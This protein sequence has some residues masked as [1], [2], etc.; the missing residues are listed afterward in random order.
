MCTASALIRQCVQYEI[1]TPDCAKSKFACPS[2]ERFPSGPGDNVSPLVSV[3]M[4]EKL[5]EMQEKRSR[6]KKEKR[7]L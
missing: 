1:A 6:D 5:N 7:K 2:P 3:Q 4:K